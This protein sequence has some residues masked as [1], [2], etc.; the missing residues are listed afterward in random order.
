MFSAAFSSGQ[1]GGNGTSVRLSGSLSLRVVCQAALSSM[2]RAWAPGATAKLINMPLHGFG[3]G[4]RHDDCDPG[5]AARTDCA[6]QIGVFVTLILGLARSRALFGPLVD[7]TVL[8]PDAHLVLEPD[9]DRRCRR[10]RIHNLCDQSGE[11]FL[12]AVI[13]CA[14]CAGCC[15]RALICEK[16]SLLST[17]PIATVD[18]STPKRCP[19]TRCKST[20][21]QRT[22]PSF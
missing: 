18:R 3:V 14:S 4:M 20:P 5:I 7:Q 15:G 12:K 2:I 21:R 8:L 22:T 1:A 19:R 9:L 10:K 11:V 13:A 16:P 6:E 17:R